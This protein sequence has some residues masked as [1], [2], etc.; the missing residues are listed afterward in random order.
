[1]LAQSSKDRGEVE[2]LLSRYMYLHNAFHDPEIV[3]LWVS[4]GTPGVQA[5]YSNDGLFTN[6]DNIMAYH[7]QR[8]NPPSREGDN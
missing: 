8:P 1:M 6:W 2:N 7:A 3:P 4:K 5:Q